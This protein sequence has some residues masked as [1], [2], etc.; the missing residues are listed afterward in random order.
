M[1]LRATPLVRWLMPLGMVLGIAMFVYSHVTDVDT[2]KMDFALSVEG[3]TEVPVYEIKVYDFALRNTVKMMWDSGAWPLAIL[4]VWCSVIWVYLKMFS[5]LVLWFTPIPVA[6]SSKIL[7]ML[8]VAG[9]WSFLDM[10]VGALYQVG[11]N[12][13][14]TKL[15]VFMDANIGLETQPAAYVFCTAAI[16]ALLL[17]HI[18]VEIHRK[19]VVT[20]EHEAQQLRRRLARP[21]L[22]AAASTTASASTRSAVGALQ[23]SSLLQQS[24]L[25]ERGGASVASGVAA[26]NGALERQRSAGDMEED[27]SGAVWASVCPGCSLALRPLCRVVCCGTREEDRHC[28]LLPP[29][30]TR[31]IALFTRRHALAIKGVLALGILGTIGLTVT[32]EF[33]F[34]R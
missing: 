31:A 2:E 10:Y 17:T 7:Y 29:P 11:L 12:V 28:T 14:I 15:L 9:K 16:W 1:A 3:G 23:H 19:S 21:P 32:G 13:H 8:D 6:L 18:M 26:A 24:L 34:Y 20:R 33:F 30:V 27:M 4:I 25:T 5:L 22:F